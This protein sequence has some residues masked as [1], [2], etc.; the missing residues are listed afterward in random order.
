MSRRCD[1]CNKGIDFHLLLNSKFSTIIYLFEFWIRHTN[2][3]GKIFCTL[4]NAGILSYKKY[5]CQKI[6]NS[7]LWKFEKFQAAY[8]L[9][10]WNNS[11]QWFLTYTLLKNVIVFRS[12]IIICSPHEISAQFYEFKIDHIF[13]IVLLSIINAVKDFLHLKLDTYERKKIKL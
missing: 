8:F 13:Y 12:V 9:I 4:H 2:I 7:S 5:Y 11:D 1:F 3:F 6:L 10:Q